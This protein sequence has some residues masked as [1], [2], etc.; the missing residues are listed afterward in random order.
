MLNLALWK[1][2]VSDAW[3]AL[4]ISAA[5]LVLFCWLF[6]WWMSLFD[7]GAWSTMLNLLPNFVQPMLGVPLAKLAT[8][9]GQLSILYAHVV[10]ILLCVGWA[11]G[12]GSASISGEIGRGTMDL[13]LSLPVWRVSV[14]AVP[15]IVAT[16]G[17]AVL[18][19]SVWAG[20]GLGLLCVRFKSP[21]PLMDFLPGAVNLFAM[22]FCFTGI[23][24]LVSSWNRDRW[25]TISIAGGFFVLSLILKFT[26]RMWAGGAWLGCLS[27]LTLFRPQE[28]ILVPA[29]DGW[30]G[31]RSDGILLLL[32]LGSYAVA[33]A[34]LW[35]RDIPAPL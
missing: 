35:R 26:A 24:T 7:M 6:V 33:A 14:M 12:R 27:F 34:I 9:A 13:L 30:G 22:T 23:T 21:P 15:A 5:L 29:A 17:A 2:A 1:K 32:G 10:T 25:R 18:A 3:L 16:V 20:M 28:L 19:A 31:F 11:V 8:P 4:L